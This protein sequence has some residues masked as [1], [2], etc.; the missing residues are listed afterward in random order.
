[1]IFHKQFIDFKLAEDFSE[2]PGGRHDEDSYF[3]ADSLKRH[4]FYL[5]QENKDKILIINLD[6]TM[7]ISS[8]FLHELVAH[9]DKEYLDRM[10]F[11]STRKSYL[12]ELTLYN[13]NVI[14]RH[15]SS[16]ETF[17][18]RVRKIFYD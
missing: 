17:W 9:T 18:Q 14:V 7:G 11:T 13:K 12:Q 1:M 16:K 2:F 3:S 6:N 4:L 15:I 10:I 5:L 8:A